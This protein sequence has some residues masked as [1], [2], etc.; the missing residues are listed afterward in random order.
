VIKTIRVSVNIKYI[1]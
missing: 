1:C